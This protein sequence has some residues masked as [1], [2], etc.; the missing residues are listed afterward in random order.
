MAV[1]VSDNV[2]MPRRDPSFSDEREPMP[3]N[4]PADKCDGVDLVG[5]NDR[6]TDDILGR[7]MGQEAFS[8]GTIEVGSLSSGIFTGIGSGASENDGSLLGIS[9]L[10]ETG[11]AM[12]YCMKS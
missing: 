3:V 10:S 4:M 8:G 5:G 1:P 2:E 6:F 11:T 9:T 12:R 7:W